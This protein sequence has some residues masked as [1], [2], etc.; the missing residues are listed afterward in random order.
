[1][2]LGRLITPFPQANM[3]QLPLVVPR[4]GPPL[5]PAEA[6][7]GFEMAW[8]DALGPMRV[9]AV[10]VR[11][12]PVA[13][14]VC[15]HLQAIPRRLLLGQTHRR[16]ST[17]DKVYTRMQAMSR[18]RSAVTC[19]PWPANWQAHVFNYTPLYPHATRNRHC[20]ATSQLSLAS[21]GR[22]TWAGRWLAREASCCLS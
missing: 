18:C 19:K 12:G 2:V 11:A 16:Q 15:Y 14:H 9:P 8:A 3:G 5:L 1:M 13:L 21:P 6:V 22:R 20:R 10:S 4:C 7:D 17:H